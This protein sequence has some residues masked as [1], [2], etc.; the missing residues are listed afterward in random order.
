MLWI[1]HSSTYEDARVYQ[2]AQI[3]TALRESIHELEFFY[4]SL[5]RKDIPKLEPNI[6]HPRFFPYPNSFLE[7]NKEVLF[8]YVKPLEDNATCV[9]FLVQMKD[10]SQVVV[11]FIDQ[12]G[13]AVHEFLAKLGYAPRLRYCA[14]F[15]FPQ[16]AQPLLPSKP[17]LSLGPLQMVVMDYVE[18]LSQDLPQVVHPQIV[19]ILKE[20]HQNGYVFGD[21]RRP[22]ITLNQAKKI[23]LI[24]FDWAG[25]YNTSFQDDIPDDIRKLIPADILKPTNVIQAQTDT[26]F[27][28]Y[29]LNLSENLFSST[30]ANDLQPI[31]PIHDWVMLNKLTFTH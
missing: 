30:G 23:Q 13:S 24:D 6:P 5:S 22:N 20:L 16:P 31:R 18:P 2:L 26:T 29:P 17:G 9:A 14:P 12:Y 11:K 8:N 10:S 1:A 19:Q 15:S 28:H 27:A 25:R 21:L 4:T 7:R 3:L